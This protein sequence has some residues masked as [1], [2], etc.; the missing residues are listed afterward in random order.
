MPEESLDRLF[1]ALSAATRRRILAHLKAGE[2]TVQ[3]IAAPFAVSLNAV[4]KHLK[5]LE[6]A[7]L[8]RR[9]VRGREH[10]CTLVPSTIRRV[11]TFAE[12]YRPFWEKRLDAFERTLSRRYPP[13]NKR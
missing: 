8:V 4:S 12:A 11:A 7:G 6:D 13:R 10:Y 5:V 9:D 1:F 2:A 3:E